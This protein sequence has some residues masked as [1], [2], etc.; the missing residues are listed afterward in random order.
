LPEG[1]HGYLVYL[2]IPARGLGALEVEARDTENSV[3]RY[4]PAEVEATDS[5]E[6]ERRTSK[7]P[8]ARLRTRLIPE[9]AP[10]DG[11]VSLGVVQAGRVT[12]AGPQYE[13][14]YIPPWVDCQTSYQLS[15]HMSD[16]LSRLRAFGD[17]MAQR[18]GDSERLP[19]T[20]VQNAMM[21][22]MVNRYDSIVAYMAELPGLHPERFYETA[23]G[24]AGELSTFNLPR[25][26]PE[27]FRGY[28]HHD[29]RGSFEP[30]LNAIRAALIGIPESDAKELP[31]TTPAPN[32]WVAAIP[33]VAMLQSSE[34]YLAVAAD[35]PTEELA[36]IYENLVT[37]GA[38]ERLRDL[39]VHSIKGV[40][41]VR[42]P[43]AP[44]AV[45]PHGGSLYYRLERNDENF[46]GITN[47][48][49]LHVNHDLRRLPNLSMTLWVV[50]PN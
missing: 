31:L 42:E 10:R 34:F 37:L 43:M 11:Y 3:A 46:K 27:Q 8:V 48:L 35:V 13:T 17:E 49:A 23:V 40:P 18:I 21:L 1:E 41:L 15:S 2:C 7:V 9:N 26:R 47:A 20:Q 38:Q 24:L 36:S 50:A 6:R 25:R 16:L 29:L 5:T 22:A 19:A 28:R 30:V 44:A 33:S 45:P 14:S 32:V 4:Y 39:V 12:S